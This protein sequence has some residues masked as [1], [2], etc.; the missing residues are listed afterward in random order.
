MYER[1]T[2]VFRPQ[3]IQRLH[4]KSITRAPA[5]PQERHAIFITHPFIDHRI[6]LAVVPTYFKFYSS[7][8]KANNETKACGS[9]VW[10]VW[11]VW[12]C[13]SSDG[14]VTCARYVTAPVHRAALGSVATNFTTGSSATLRVGP[15]R[16]GGVISPC[17]LISAADIGE[18][19]GRTRVTSVSQRC[20]SHQ[21]GVMGKRTES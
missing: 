7:G 19:C 11:T 1:T 13:N 15:R 5:A 10:T 17:V 2:V 6:Y 4:N 20:T 3:C 16:A 14:S 18:V 9:T 12:T 8:S 21:Q